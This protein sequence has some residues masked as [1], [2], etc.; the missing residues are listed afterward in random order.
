MWGTLT[1]IGVKVG[2]AAALAFTAAAAARYLHRAR[3]TWRPANRS[4][5]VVETAVLGQQRALH[6]VSVGDRTLLI[7]STQGQVAMLAD[8]TGSRGEAGEQEASRP[9]FA[10]M[11]ADLLAPGR[12]EAP[13]E[14][15]A[16]LHEAAEKL[17]REGG[18]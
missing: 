1:A 13:P 14:Q 10:A 12:E 2:L 17:R 18:P 8:V 16:H 9:T 15:A 6:L 5:R 7:A 4:L 3:F 11:V